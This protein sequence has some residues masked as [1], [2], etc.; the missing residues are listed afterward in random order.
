MY[1]LDIIVIRPANWDSA[2]LRGAPID[3][4]NHPEDS[5]VIK[6]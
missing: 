3:R 5:A 1:P 4:E 2:A 6:E